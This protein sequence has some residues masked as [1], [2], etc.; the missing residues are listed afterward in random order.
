MAD[1]FIP[2]TI[3][4]NGVQVPIRIA[5][6]DYDSKNAFTRDYGRLTGIWNRASALARLALVKAG[7]PTKP[8]PPEEAPDSEAAEAMAARLE[9]NAEKIRVHVENTTIALALREL[10]ETP[11]E[12]A[13]RDALEAEYDAF[14]TGFIKQ[15]FDRFVSIDPD[16]VLLDA[17]GLR[18]QTGLDLLRAYPS[19]AL[20][21]DVIA[22]VLLQNSLSADLKKKL[23]SRSASAPSS[24]GKSE[25]SP[26]ASGA[27][28]A[29]I[30]IS[31]LISD[32][33]NVEG[34]TV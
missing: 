2:T 5:R 20:Y 30:A 19:L 24:D 27:A 9:R 10:E 25:T 13:R 18:V 17:D 15:T 28:P 8:D 3:D 26:T 21:S 33:A 31:A 12:R 23:D 11:A 14:A 4:V 7:M 1:S 6:F 32:S 34:V 16:Y 29:P 22:K